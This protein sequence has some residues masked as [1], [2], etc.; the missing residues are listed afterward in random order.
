MAFPAIAA[1]NRSFFLDIHTRVW[2]H[3]SEWLKTR[4]L[5][6]LFQAAATPKKKEGVRN[7][8]LLTRQAMEEEEMGSRTQ[9]CQIGEKLE[10]FLEGTKKASFFARNWNLK[11]IFIRKLMISHIW[12]L[13]FQPSLIMSRGSALKKKKKGKAGGWQPDSCGTKSSSSSQDL[14]WAVR[15]I[16]DPPPSL[17]LF[18][19][20]GICP[21]QEEGEEN[22]LVT[23]S[24]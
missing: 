14:M 24:H 11:V 10:S 7:M 13:Y 6:P 16:C 20:E 19:R 12:H 21:L 18:R 9:G 8:A 22:W 3:S 23:S 1:K 15:E 2:Q 17:L 5:L 4:R